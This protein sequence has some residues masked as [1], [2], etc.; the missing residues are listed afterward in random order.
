MTFQPPPGLRNPHVQTIV[1]GTAPRRWWLAGRTKRLRSQLEEVVLECSEGVRL[2]GEYLP[3][4]GAGSL[5]LLI[6]GWVGCSASGYMQ[7]VRASLH[8]AGHAV[9][10]L[11]LRDHGPSAHLNR[12]PFLAIRLTEVS[13]AVELVQQRYP[14][15]HQSLVGF[16]LGGNIALRV[17][18]HTAERAIRLDQVVAFCPPV[19]PAATA[20]AI[21]SQ[22]IYNRHFV[23]A[24]RQ[25]FAEKVRHYPELAQ[26]ADVFEQD[27]IIR[28]HEAFVPRFSCHPDAA[29]YFQAYT[30]NGSLL[31]SLC[32]PAHVVLAADDPVIPV[33]SRDL[34][35]PLPELSVELSAHGGHCGFLQNYRLQGWMD[36]RALDLLPPAQAVDAE[37]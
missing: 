30:L 13:D 17:A 32:C 19:D 4:A 16:S 27:D 21:S 5:V 34:L 12:D 22:R 37:P 35:P 23:A 3:C 28:L 6:H 20:R 7:S 18:A 26:H 31:Q 33:D 29:S 15:R 9:F 2:H 14:H 8:R 36:E 11:H 10:V 25:A 1:A 24:W